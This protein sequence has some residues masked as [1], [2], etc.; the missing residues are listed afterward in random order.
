MHEVFVK[1]VDWNGKTF[2]GE[3]FS[4]NPPWLKECLQAGRIAIIPDKERDYAIWAVIT[5]EKVIVA[6][7]GDRINM[8]PMFGLVVEKNSKNK[9]V[10]EDYQ[11]KEK[12]V[13]KSKK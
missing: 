13:R 4:D 10:W 8:D 7:P 2:D 12:K 5:E 3:P 6:E 1:S 9:A 11:P